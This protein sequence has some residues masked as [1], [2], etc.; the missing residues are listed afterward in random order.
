MGLWLRLHLCHRLSLSL[1]PDPLADLKQTSVKM[2]QGGLEVVEGHVPVAWKVV[3]A[4]TAE[5]Q[6]TAM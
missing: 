6:P 2:T 1:S 3:A 4:S 5:V